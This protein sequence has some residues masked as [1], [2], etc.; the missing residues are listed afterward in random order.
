MPSNL[1]VFDRT[2]KNVRAEEKFYNHQ[3]TSLIKYDKSFKDL[4]DTLKSTPQIKQCGYIPYTET[5]LNA[6]LNSIDIWDY[7]GIRL[8][9]ISMLSFPIE[10]NGSTTLTLSRDIIDS[11]RDV[12][13]I[14]LPISFNAKYGYEGGIVSYNLTNKSNNE[15]CILFSEIFIPPFG[16]ELSSCAYIHEIAHTQM[17]VSD[18]T[19][20]DILNHETIPILMEEIYAYHQDPSGNLLKRMRYFRLLNLQNHLETIFGKKPCYSDRVEIDTYIK[21]IIQAIKIANFY[22]SASEGQRKE[23]LGYINQ[24][25]SEERNLDDMLSFYGINYLDFSLSE[26]KRIRSK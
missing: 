18:G 8:Q 10:N 1:Y 13:P 2:I 15:K 6:V 26:L 20:L 21:S 9:E 14:E 11:V 17:L 4:K 25:F 7:L 5:S 16:D 3:K 22:F 19:G 24:I 12:L 23:L